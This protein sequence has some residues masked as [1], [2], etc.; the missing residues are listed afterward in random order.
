M[1][2]NFGMYIHGANGKFPLFLMAIKK[3]QFS[4]VNRILAGVKVIVRPIL[5]ITRLALLILESDRLCDKQC[6][7][8]LKVPPKLEETKLIPP[9]NNA[10]PLKTSRGKG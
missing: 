7:K 4:L 5:E 1:N 10:R 8:K 6:V 2:I 9:K 3:E